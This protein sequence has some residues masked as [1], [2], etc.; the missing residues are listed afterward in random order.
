[1]RDGETPHRCS[2]GLFLIEINLHPHRLLKEKH[3]PNKKA[4]SRKQKRKKINETLS[5]QGRT[6]IQYKKYLIKTRNR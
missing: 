5:R 6:S 1:M 2:V 4:K 3:M